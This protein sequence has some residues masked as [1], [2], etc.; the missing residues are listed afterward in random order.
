[1]GLDVYASNTPDEIALTPEQAQAFEDADISLC[2]GIFSG[3]G[4]SFRGKVYV[5]LVLEITGESL[6]QDWIPPETVREMYAALLACDAKD[7]VEDGDL[8]RNTPQDV[9]ELRRFFEVCADHGL[10]L[11]GWW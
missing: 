6:L 2:G 11:I 9:V 5:D 1:M 4:G 7:A 3:S 10:G 8:E